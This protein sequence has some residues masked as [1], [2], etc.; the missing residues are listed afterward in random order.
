MLFRSL[1]KVHFWGSMVGMNGV[2]L[3]MFVLGLQGQSR[4][5]YDPTAQLHNLIG[6]PMHVVSTV[7]AFILLLA[8]LPFIYNFFNSMFN[9]EK[10]GTNPW[11]ATTLD[12]L[13]PS[14]PPHGNFESVP[15]VYRG[16]YEYSHPDHKDDWLPQTAEKATA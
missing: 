2:F 7:S 13:C 15:K 10:V 16:P 1:G 9:G 8:Q 5:L 4:R 14:P 6:Q 11:Q 12:W 3:P